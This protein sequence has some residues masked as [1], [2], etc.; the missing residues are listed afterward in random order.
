ME[1]LLN[2]VRKVTEPALEVLLLVAVLASVVG[3][4]TTHVAEGITAGG[5]NASTA[6]VAFAIVAYVWKKVR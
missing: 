6:L 3:L 1:S 4:Y 2:S 5:V